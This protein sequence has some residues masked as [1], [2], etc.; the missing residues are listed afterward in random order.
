MEI[1]EAYIS[2]II[3]HHFSIDE[4]RRLVNN[5]EMNIQNIDACLLR[6]FFIKPFANQRSEYSFSH[7]VSL[8]YNIVYQSSLDV[9]QNNDFVKSSKH[10]F[11]HL[12]SVSNVPTIKD[13][14][15]FVTLI[16]DVKI[17]DSYYQALGIFKIETKSEFIETYVDNNGEMSFEVKSG[18]SSNKID[19]ASLIVFT[20]K[21]PTCYI[22]DTSKDTKFW[23]QEFLGMVSKANNYSKTKASNRVFQEFINNELPLHKEISKDEQVQLVN[24]FTEMVKTSEEVSVSEIADALFDD[25]KVNSAFADYKK[26]FEEKESMEIGDVFNFD[27][28]AFTVSRNA[29]RI[30]L[31]DTAEIHLLKTGGFIERGYDEERGMRYYKLFFNEEK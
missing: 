25:P 21:Q 10:I 20:E 11:K 29:R 1:K 8:S 2:R 17:F 28:K 18:F 4:T 26:I 13:G 3:C 15:V 12:E 9:F 19:K 6:D 22:L 16:E 31:D 5:A 7:P 23:R 14:D 30:K 24:R 27:K